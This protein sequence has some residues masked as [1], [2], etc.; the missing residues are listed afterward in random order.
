MTLKLGLIADDKPVK[1]IVEMPADIF[2][3]LTAYAE[4]H[5][6]ATGQTALPPSKLVV[7]MLA[8]F[9]ASDRGFA[10]LRRA[11]PGKPPPGS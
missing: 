10:K 11:L 3:D 9:M 7:P 6:A 8:Q 1:L 2:R 5:A 4:V